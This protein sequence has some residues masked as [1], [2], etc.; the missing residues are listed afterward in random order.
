M[1]VLLWGDA[2]L[3][4]RMSQ[5]LTQLCHGCRCVCPCVAAGCADVRRPGIVDAGGPVATRA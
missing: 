5:S 4:S 3:F 1:C 2:V